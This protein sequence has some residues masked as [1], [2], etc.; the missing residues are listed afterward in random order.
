MSHEME[1]SPKREKSFFQGPVVTFLVKVVA[2]GIFTVSLFISLFFVIILIVMGASVAAGDRTQE[3]Y[4][5]IYS[6]WNQ[7]IPGGDGPDEVAVVYING[8]ITEYDQ[9]DGFLG[10]RESPLSAV[11]NRFNLIRKDDY[12]RGILLVIDSPGGGVTASDV[13]FNYIMKFKEETGLPV[14]TLM[15]QVAASGAYYIAAA[16]DVIIA[17]PTAITGSIGVIMYGFNVTGLMEKYGVEYVAIKTSEHKDSISP[18]K[19]VDQ[20]EVAWMQSIVD[21]MLERFI[22]AV[23]LG[24]ESL[25]V[26]EV[27]KIADGKIYIAEEALKAGLIDRIGYFEDAV[28][29]LSEKA[30]IEGPVIVEYERERNIKDIIGRV[31]VN[32][33]GSFIEER[34]L[35]AT[36]SQP[37]ELY[38]LWDASLMVR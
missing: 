23:A 9:Q 34:V 35:R 6:D 1:G 28:G 19:P 14:V 2:V 30:G 3:G 13:L 5:K 29:I 22:E 11:R 26:D 8:I 24:R 16:S 32:L 37:F 38:Y 17:Y 21:S 4:T 20:E 31:M 33:P 7:I 18:F 27:R 12:I 36:H 10:Y 15:K 25:D